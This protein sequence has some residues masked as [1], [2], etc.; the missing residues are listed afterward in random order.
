MVRPRTRWFRAA[1][2]VGARE[3]YLRLSNILYVRALLVDPHRIF[4]PS[5][6][7]EPIALIVASRRREASRWTGDHELSRRRRRRGGRGYCCIGHLCSSS[8]LRLP[9]AS[10]LH[11]IHRILEVPRRRK[12]KSIVSTRCI[13]ALWEENDGAFRVRGEHARQKNQGQQ[14]QQEP[15]WRREF[16][17]TTAQSGSGSSGETKENI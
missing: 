16:F 1:S 2:D 17:S 3:K 12:K 9:Y 5:S 15:F 4:A 11:C 8:R 14:Q 10:I 7:R 6:G 13:E